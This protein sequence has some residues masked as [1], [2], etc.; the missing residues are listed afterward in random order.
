MVG[1]E[2]YRVI[3]AVGQAAPPVTGREHGRDPEDRVCHQ[4]ARL[5]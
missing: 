5:C 2:T 4:H 3:N 1:D